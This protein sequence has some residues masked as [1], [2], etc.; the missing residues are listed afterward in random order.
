MAP[1][2]G[3]LFVGGM[4]DRKRAGGSLEYTHRFAEW[5]AAYAKAS[6]WRNWSGE[7]DASAV[8]GG[9]IQW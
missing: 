2:S 1:G 8:F 6:G 4:I 3:S 9:E 5:G 7:W